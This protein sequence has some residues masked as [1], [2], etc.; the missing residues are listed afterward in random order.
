MINELIHF[1][2]GVVSWCVTTY[3]S[4][5]RFCFSCGRLLLTSPLELLLLP[6]KIFDDVSRRASSLALSALKINALLFCL[7][8]SLI[9]IF[10]FSP[11]VDRFTQIVFLLTNSMSLLLTLILGNRIFFD[12]VNS[13]DLI[14][15]SISFALVTF[16]GSGLLLGILCNGTLQQRLLILAVGFHFCFHYFS[17][18]PFGGGGSEEE[19]ASTTKEQKAPLF[20]WNGTHFVHLD[21]DE[22]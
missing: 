14:R 9:L 3:V 10:L 11:S 18:S 13:W 5:L 7:L 16:G 15:S 2:A 1:A 22:L 12:G 8:C 19:D 21:R 20:T 6:A 4:F 17:F